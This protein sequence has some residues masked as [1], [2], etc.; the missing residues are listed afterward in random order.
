MS[1]QSDD[2]G[3]NDPPANDDQNSAYSALQD[4]LI[5]PVGVN[6][7]ILWK[8]FGFPYAKHY[9]ILTRKEVFCK[10]CLEKAAEMSVDVLFKL[11]LHLLSC[12][13]SLY[14]EVRAAEADDPM[15]ELTKI[16]T[17]L[18][19]KDDPSFRLNYDTDD[20]DYDEEC[21]WVTHT[22]EFIF[23]SKN[24]D[25]KKKDFEESFLYC[26]RSLRTWQFSPMPRFFNKYDDCKYVRLRHLLHKTG[27]DEKTVLE[28]AS[29]HHKLVKPKLVEKIKMMSEY[30]ISIEDWCSRFTVSVNYLE[31]STLQNSILFTRYVQEF[32]MKKL[33]GFLQKY[34]G[35]QKEKIVAV[36]APVEY[37]E[38]EKMCLQEQ[39]LAPVIPCFL[40]FLHKVAR[41]DLL[42]M[43]QI[44]KYISENVYNNPNYMGTCSF[45]D[46][47]YW[48]RYYLIF[49]SGLEDVRRNW[50]KAP[51]KR[52]YPALRYLASA[53]DVLYLALETFRREH[54][55]GNVSVLWPILAHLKK[56]FEPK[57]NDDAFQTEVKRLVQKRI[58]DHYTKVMPFLKAA[59]MVDP[60]YR[61]EKNYKKYFIIYITKTLI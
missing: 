36:I 30:S 6:C 55:Y 18:L 48:E 35:I 4:N 57:Q 28:L 5:L 45:M 24:V 60:R 38:D 32:Q 41:E 40:D 11:R 54:P 1:S 44:R 58:N 23:D 37:V 15:M 13:P 8:H 43:E 22:R 59:T 12:N 9:S 21:P 19:S 61:Y 27:P 14:E 2:D 42:E 29:K 20:G 33:V 47:K 51:T 16:P 17:I 34:W 10:S 46:M 31:G 39:L 52:D 49:T 3:M 25:Q 50:P 56:E 7:S 26:I 53:L